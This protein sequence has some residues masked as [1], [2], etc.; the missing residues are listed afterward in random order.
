MKNIILT[1]VALLSF[2]LSYS[3]NVF[4]NN[5]ISLDYLISDNK[6]NPALACDLY[7]VTGQTRNQFGQNYSIPLRVCA[8]KII[9]QYSISYVEAN[10][11]GRWQ[12]KRHTSDF[13]DRG[14]YYVTVGQYTYYFKF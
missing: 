8:T 5:E 11:N 12:R 14:T 13:T 10:V 7:A 4:P 6:N 1:S 3:S 2:T 9:N